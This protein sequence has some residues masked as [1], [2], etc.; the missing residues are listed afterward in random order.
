VKTISG[1]EK[2]KPWMKAAGKLRHL[3]AETARIQRIIDEEFGQ[4]EV[5]PHPRAARHAS[6]GQIRRKWSKE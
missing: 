3:H 6:Q 1:T 4:I 2:L 5:N